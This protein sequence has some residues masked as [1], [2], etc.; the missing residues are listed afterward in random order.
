[1]LRPVLWPFTA[2]TLKITVAFFTHLYTCVLGTVTVNHLDIS[3]GTVAGEWNSKEPMLQARYGFGIGTDPTQRYI[4]VMGGNNGNKGGDTFLDSIHKY[5]TENNKWTVLSTKLHKKG[6]ATAAPGLDG[7]K[8]WVYQKKS[9]AV[10]TFDTE[11]EYIGKPLKHAGIPKS[12]IIFPAKV[13]YHNRLFSK[14]GPYRG[15]KL[16]S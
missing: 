13:S 2:Q 15:V 14:I 9:P 1:M 11:S 6:V 7:T 3:Q 4:F 16:N 5:A 8:I 12:K 10:F